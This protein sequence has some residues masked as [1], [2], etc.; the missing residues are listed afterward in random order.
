M[1]HLNIYPKDASTRTSPCLHSPARSLTCEL[2]EYK[3]TTTII[4]SKPN[5]LING[6]PCDYRRHQMPN[7]HWTYDPSDKRIGEKNA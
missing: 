6:L 3:Y 4:R 5:N 2:I 1:A 7:V